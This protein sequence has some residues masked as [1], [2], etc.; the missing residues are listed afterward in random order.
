MQTTTWETLARIQ[1]ARQANK[2]AEVSALLK[3]LHTG[4]H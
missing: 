3:S 4:E 1:I 2:T